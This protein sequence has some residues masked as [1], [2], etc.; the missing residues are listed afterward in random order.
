M[1]KG[2]ILAVS[3]QAY[4]IENSYS[5]G[6][7]LVIPEKHAESIADLPDDW[8]RD[9][10]ELLPHIPNLPEDYNLAMNHGV[11]AGQSIKHFHLW[12]IPRVAGKPSSGKGFARLI[13]EADDTSSVG[14]E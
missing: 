3:K 11:L 10:K 1:L 9:V 6:S 2:D 4:L 8:F 14:N 5:K 7:Y 13:I 12:V